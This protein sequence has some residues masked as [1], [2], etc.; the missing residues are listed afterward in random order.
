MP[1][2]AFSSTT[3]ACDRITAVSITSPMNVTTDICLGPSELRVPGY[4]P[5][6]PG[7]RPRSGKF[8]GVGGVP[9][10]RGVVVSQ[11]RLATGPFGDSTQGGMSAP[12]PDDHDS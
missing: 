7:D 10:R 8:G 2:S 11:R 5:H 12:S 6:M 1:A 4:V 9:A 3:C